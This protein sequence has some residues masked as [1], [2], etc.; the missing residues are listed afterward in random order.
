MSLFDQFLIIAAII[1]SF[2]GCAT[3]SMDRAVEA[4]TVSAVSE[5][6]YSDSASQVEGTIYF[7]YDK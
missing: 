1:C 4:E 2:S 3:V 7:E 6:E 5:S